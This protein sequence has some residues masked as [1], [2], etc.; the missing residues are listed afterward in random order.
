[1]NVST[2]IVERVMVY[3]RLRPFTADEY[4]KEKQTCIET[5]DKDKKV[6]VGTL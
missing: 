2:S 6:I 5:F 1:M 4:A 3:C